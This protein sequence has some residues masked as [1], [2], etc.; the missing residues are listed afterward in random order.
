L[1][2]HVLLEARSEFANGDPGQMARSSG[3]E[4]LPERQ[5][6]RLN[7]LNSFYD[8]S[9]PDGEITGEGAGA[10]NQDEEAILLKYLNQVGGIDPIGRWMAFAE[11]PNGM[12]HDAP[13]KIEAIRPLGEFFDQQPQRLAQSARQLGGKQIELAGDLSVAIPVFPRLLIAVL[14]WVGD[15]EFPG[16]ANMLFDAAAISHLSTASLYVLGI[17]LSRHLRQLAGQE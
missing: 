9:F 5:A 15:E 8:V 3:S 4:F 13:F 2:P 6:V 1:I 12:F 10:L 14:L 16:R 11:L 7:Y 17:N